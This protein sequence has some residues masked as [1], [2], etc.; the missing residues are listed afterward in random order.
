MAGQIITA[1]PPEQQ[2]R[3]RKDVIGALNAYTKGTSDEN[4]IL[5]YFQGY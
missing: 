3:I 5:S 4:D 2:D 1:A